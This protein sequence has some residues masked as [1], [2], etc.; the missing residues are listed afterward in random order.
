MHF[1]RLLLL[2]LADIF[3]LLLWSYLFITAISVHY[4]H[5]YQSHAYRPDHWYSMYAT[6]PVFMAMH[7]HGIL[8]V[9]LPESLLPSSGQSSSNNQYFRFTLFF[10]LS[11]TMA[12]LILAS[13]FRKR[14]H[15]DLPDVLFAT[16]TTSCGFIL[17]H[18]LGCLEISSWL[19]YLGEVTFFCACFAQSNVRH[20]LIS[21]FVVIFCVMLCYVMHPYFLHSYA[22]SSSNYSVHSKFTQVYWPRHS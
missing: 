4:S 5:L 19:L 17:L 8:N 15:K 3:G 16:A 10:F 12:L 7:I 14:E 20:Y 22:F 21:H 9:L 1:R 2:V 13:D 11:V 6:T 18:H